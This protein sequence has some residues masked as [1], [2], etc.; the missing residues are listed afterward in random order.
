MIV[1]DGKLIDTDTGEILEDVAGLSYGQIGR[2]MWQKH[3]DIYEARKV[4]REVQNDI[5]N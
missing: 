4:F 2:L 1:F 5:W 3:R